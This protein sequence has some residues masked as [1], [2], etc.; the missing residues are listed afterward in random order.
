MMGLQIAVEEIEGVRVLRVEGRLDIANAP[1]LDRKID[2]LIDDKHHKFAIDFSGIDYLSSSGM[3]VL[4]S[5]TK[6][7]RSQKGDLF[8]FSVTSE[9]E[10]A[11]KMVGF[12]R[13][14]NIYSNEQEA[15]QGLHK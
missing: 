14:L 11:L 2:S 9:V 3:R 7:L 12:D 6:Q 1:I 4:L 13:F 10:D 15:M 5:K 8:L